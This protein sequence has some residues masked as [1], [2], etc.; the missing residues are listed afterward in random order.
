MQERGGE[1][2]EEEEKL[3]WTRASWPGETTNGKG[4][5]SW[6]ITQYSVRSAQPRHMAYNYNNQTMFLYGHIEV[7]NYYN[8]G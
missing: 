3:R 7:V 6:G 2:E 1:N 5:Y 8:S 4:S